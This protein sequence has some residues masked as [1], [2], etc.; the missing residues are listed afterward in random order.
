MLI[1][2]KLNMKKNISAGGVILN[3]ENKILVVEQKHNCWSLPKGHVEEGEDLL[4]AAKREIY[5]ESGIRNLEMVKPLGNYER[6]RIGLGGEDDQT[7]K[8]EIHMF[9]FRTNE[10][11]L[12]PQDADNPSARW[13]R[14]EEVANLLTHRKDKEFFLS[15]ISEL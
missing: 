11:D 15:I 4:T 6:F 5:E 10:T 14:K 9:L 13:V 8:K 7:E 3:S 12:Q 1:I 2:E